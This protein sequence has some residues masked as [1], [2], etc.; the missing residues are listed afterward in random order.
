MHTV[1][2]ANSYRGADAARYAPE[3]VQVVDDLAAA[4]TC[5]RTQPRSKS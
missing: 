1:D 5:R 3:A 4:G 2:A